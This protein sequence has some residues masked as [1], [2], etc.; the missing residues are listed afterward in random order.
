MNE[1]L[2]GDRATPELKLKKPLDMRWLSH[3]AACHTLVK[4]LP[5]LITSL[6]QE[7]SERGDAL[8]LCRV[9]KEYN[10]IASLYM[11]CDVLPPV[12]RLS[13]I[14]QSSTNLLI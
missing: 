13:R 5:A 11:I 3:D 4:V 6:E 1:W 10:F 2:E 14:F 9:V 7:A 12:S 8:G